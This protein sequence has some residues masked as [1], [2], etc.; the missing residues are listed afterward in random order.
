MFQ[1][2]GSL[3]KLICKWWPFST[4]KCHQNLKL[5]NIL[6]LLDVSSVQSFS[7]V[8]LFATSWTVACQASLS[9]TN[10]RS[11]LKLTSIE[12]VI[13]S[14]QLILC[15]P[16]SSPSPTFNLFQH[17]CLFQ[18]VSSSHQVA[19]ILELQLQNQ[20]FQW[21]PRTDLLYNWLVGSH[22]SPR[23]SQGSSPTPKFKSINS[24][25][26]SFLYSPTL[27]SIQGYWKNHGFD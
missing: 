23:D 20:S 27:T 13:P 9:I 6:N 22:R 18:W 26:L 24:L 15:H 10:S 19:K 2:N 14:N 16:L 21:I 12:L 4:L 17:Q 3:M 5:R 7:H 8:W 25:V 1:W 11:L